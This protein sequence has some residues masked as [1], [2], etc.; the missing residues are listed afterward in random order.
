MMTLTELSG[1]IGAGSDPVL[2]IHGLDPMI[3][4]VY[5]IVDGTPHPLCDGRK[6]MQFRSRYAAQRALAECGATTAT[7][8][9]RS[10]YGEMVGL[11]ADGAETEL[12]ETVFLSRD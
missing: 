3:Y 8:V 10:A 9:H 7:F 4:V 2:E 6:T 12:R 5:R 1:L 11:D